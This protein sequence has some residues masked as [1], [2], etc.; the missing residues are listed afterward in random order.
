MKWWPKERWPSAGGRRGKEQEKESEKERDVSEMGRLSICWSKSCPN[1]R[2]V[3][4]GGR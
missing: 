1:V 3:R 4:E 2:E